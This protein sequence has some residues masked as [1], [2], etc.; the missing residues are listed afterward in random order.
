LL[1]IYLKISC[2]FDNL[3][4]IYLK[5]FLILQYEENNVGLIYIDFLNYIFEF[6]EIEFYYYINPYKKYQAEF[7]IFY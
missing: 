1:L 7:I 5:F 6:Y 3:K 2:Y 4:F